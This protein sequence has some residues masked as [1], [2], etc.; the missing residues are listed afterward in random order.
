[1]PQ[2]QLYCHSGQR[3]SIGDSAFVECGALT[4]ITIPDG[5]TSISDAMLGGCY[6]LTSVNLSDSLKSIGSGAFSGCWELTSITIPDSVTSIDVSA[7]SNCINLQRIY[8]AGDGPIISNNIFSST[9][10][11][12]YYLPGSTGWTETFAGRP[13][14]LWN[15]QILTGDGVL[16][17][18]D[19]KFGFTISG[20][21]DVPVVVEA[22]SDL[23]DPNWTTVAA[24]TFNAEGTVVFRDPNA[25]D[26]PGRYYR[27]RPE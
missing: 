7:F 10:S 13:T 17:V 26:Q 24:L 2:T 12:L 25:A 4:T 1:M 22:C 11:T 16:G 21:A 27:F 15:P 9:P 19:G 20:A 8:F 6:S 14:V 3:D 18:Q 23:A 5:V